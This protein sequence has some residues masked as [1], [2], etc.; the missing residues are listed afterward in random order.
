MRSAWALSLLIGVVAVSRA[1]WADE[2]PPVIEHTP[3]ASATTG[4][5]V[6]IV[7]RITDE[8]EVFPP[9]VTYRAVGSG[10]KKVVNMV[11][12]KSAGKAEYFEAKINVDSSIE[13]WI[14]VYDEFG[15]GPATSGSSSRPHLIEATAPVVVERPKPAP[16]PEP[17]EKKEEQDLAPPVIVH[18]PL[19][20]VEGP[21]PYVVTATI[22]DP[23]GVFAPTVYHRSPG[24]PRYASAGM[25]KNGDTYS[26]SLNITPPFEYWLEAY[27]NFGNGPA[28]DGSAD[29]PYRVKPRQ[30][31]L[32][33]AAFAPLPPEDEFDAP[34]GSKKWWLIGGAGVVG[35][36][37]IGGVVYALASQ[38]D[39]GAWV[40]TQSST[41]RR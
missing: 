17:V 32:A 41:R 4:G 7:A 24:D 20:E 30:V 40:V 8:S 11:A 16:K 12:R 36:A 13:Y 28:Q 34:R 21:A 14:E 19:E 37:V 25:E 2:R 31:E 29:T 33:D 9:S 1:A 5:Q 6:T 27:D 15:N 26:A 35:A 39:Y 3:V 38:P 18:T 10:S 23:S 22:T